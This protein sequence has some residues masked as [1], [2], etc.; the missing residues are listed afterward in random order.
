MRTIRVGVIGCGEVAQWMHLPF[1]TE[2]PGFQ[3]TAVCDVSQKVVDY[4]GERFGVAQRFTD[5]HQLVA[6][7]DVDAVVIATPIHSDPAIAAAQA[8]KH[9]L[10][11]KPMAFNLQEAEAMVA[12]A[13]RSGII[14]MVAYM[15]RYDPGYLYGQ[16]LMQGMQDV[17]LIRVHDLNGPNAAYVRDMTTTVRDPELEAKNGPAL[18]ADI[19]RRAVVA[20]GDGHPDWVYNAYLLLGGLSSHDITILR[21]AF[22]GPRA[23][24]HTEIWQNGSYILSTLD[25]GDGCRCI[26]E[27]GTTRKKEFDEELAAFGAHSTVRIRFPSPYVKYAPTLVQVT[28]MDGDA[29]VERTVT[30]SYEESFRREL[31]H[32]HACITDGRAP[33]TPGREGL[34]DVRLQIDIIKA[35]LRQGA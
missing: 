25:Y 18:T 1:L 6:R 27:I 16:R 9:V 33:T 5:F 23:V 20:L 13:E 30:A 4:A 24:T 21:G 11:E 19:R 10:V 7:T 32:F 3:V 2:L 28:E 8:G 14:L 15:K 17:R 31:A 34:E 26:F 35:A 22:G 29:L 12:A